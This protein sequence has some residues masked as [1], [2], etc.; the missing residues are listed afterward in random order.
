M[1]EITSEDLCLV[2]NRRGL[3]YFLKERL[4]WPSVDPED[5]FAYEEPDLA[6]KAEVSRLVPFGVDDP[7]PILEKYKQG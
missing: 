6:I 5:P 3:F 2:N 4:G 7:H 1:I